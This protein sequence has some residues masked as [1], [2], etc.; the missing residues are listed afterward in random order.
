MIFLVYGWF[1]LLPVVEPDWIS[2]WASSNEMRAKSQA[3]HDSPKSSAP[4][5]GEMFGANASASARAA[6]AAFF[7]PSCQFAIADTANA[8]ALACAS[9]AGF[10]SAFAAHSPA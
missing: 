1:G 8:L 4:L 3:T 7:C 5:S 6:R 2:A 10:F 9:A